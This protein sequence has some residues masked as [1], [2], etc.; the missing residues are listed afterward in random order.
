MSY[1][2]WSDKAVSA[3]LLVRKRATARAVYTLRLC[4]SVCVREAQARCICVW[5]VSEGVLPCTENARRATARAHNSN[6]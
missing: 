4:L 3:P 1:C 2:S 6:T 5:G